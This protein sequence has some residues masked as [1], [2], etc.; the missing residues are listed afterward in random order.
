MPKVQQQ[1]QECGKIQRRGSPLARGKHGQSRIDRHRKRRAGAASS[2]LLPH[3]SRVRST[4]I[5][6][7]GFIDAGD[8]LQTGK[9][10]GKKAGYAGAQRAGSCAIICEASHQD[11]RRSVA[12]GSHLFQKFK[13]RSSWASARLQ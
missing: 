12:L 9:G 10:F 4:T 13:S 7:K 5:L 2:R 3:L 11:E 8:Q 1:R 6:A